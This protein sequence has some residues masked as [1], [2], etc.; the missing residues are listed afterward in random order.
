M[1]GISK[2]DRTLA[3]LLPIM[4]QLPIPENHEPPITATPSY[5]E[6]SEPSHEWVLSNEDKEQFLNTAY[7]VLSNTV[8]K[9]EKLKPL[10][11]LIKIAKK[12]NL[13]YF[14][15]EEIDVYE[16]SKAFSEIVVKNKLQLEATNGNPY[17]FLA[18]KGSELVEI[19]RPAVQACILEKIKEN[20]R[21]LPQGRFVFYRDKDIPRVVLN[22]IYLVGYG[23]SEVVSWPERF[24]SA[25]S[26]GVVNLGERTGEFTRDWLVVLFK[27]HLPRLVFPTVS[28]SSSSQGE[29]PAQP[30]KTE[31]EKTQI[32][33]GEQA[34]ESPTAQSESKQPSRTFTIPPLVI[35]N[36]LDAVTRVVGGSIHV[37]GGSGTPTSYNA[38][39]STPLSGPKNLPAGPSATQDHFKRSAVFDTSTGGPYV[40][41]NGATRI[42]VDNSHIMEPIQAACNKFNA[43]LANYNS[44]QE[45]LNN[46]LKSFSSNDSEADIISKNSN[47]KTI[48]QS[49]STELR[50]TLDAGWEVHKLVDHKA[51]KGYG[52]SEKDNKGYYH[53]IN[54]SVKKVLHDDLK[55]PRLKH[56][57]KK[58]LDSAGE[59]TK[60]KTL[61]NQAQSN[62]TSIKTQQAFREH[63]AFILEIESADGPTDLK[64][65]TGYLTQMRLVGSQ[66][67]SQL[68]QNGALSTQEVADSTKGIEDRIAELTSRYPRYA[69][70]LSDYDKFCDF[71]KSQLP[72]LIASENEQEIAQGLRAA[73]TRQEVLEKSIEEL[74]ENCPANLEKNNELLAI[75]EDVASRV[76]LM[77]FCARP[78]EQQSSELGV[79]K[80]QIASATTDDEREKAIEGFQTR[81]V[82]LS[83]QLAARKDY[84]KFAENFNNF[85][86]FLAQ[87]DSLP[88]MSVDQ[89]EVMSQN[90]IK[91]VVNDLIDPT[92]SIA[93]LEAIEKKHVANAALLNPLRITIGT[94]FYLSPEKTQAQ[95]I[96]WY[97]RCRKIQPSEPMWPRALAI[98]HLQT[99]H[100][101]EA[102][103]NVLDALNMAPE[104]P[105]NQAVAAQIVQDKYQNAS[106][107]LEWV[108]FILNSLTPSEKRAV[109]KL[110]SLAQIL[111][112][113]SSVASHPSLLKQW[114]PQL[115]S[116]S[117]Q[118]KEELIKLLSQE[119]DTNFNGLNV[120]TLA[121][122]TISAGA[123]L[124]ESHYTVEE[125]PI[126]VKSARLLGGISNAIQLWLIPMV[127]CSHLRN[128]GSKYATN[129]LS[130]LGYTHGAA[131]SILLPLNSLIPFVQ[132]SIYKDKNE[133]I[134]SQKKYP[135]LHAMVETLGAKHFGA[136]FGF[137]ELLWHS[138]SLIGRLVT[139]LSSKTSSQTVEK[140]VG[141]GA[142]TF[143]AYKTASIYLRSK[144]EIV[145]SQPPEPKKEEPPQPKMG[146][147]ETVKSWWCALGAKLGFSW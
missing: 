122:R 115:L 3:F 30:S 124:I 144:E 32:Q 50:K 119:I 89:L 24:F 53:D 98:S 19:F 5:P 58:S 146:I 37:S 136:V 35:P 142:V 134:E 87:E 67:V 114:L 131:V 112:A 38:Q 34:Q 57:E 65:L 54:S 49:L 15:K 16:L 4:P 17:G 27:E 128:L 109:G 96:L 129:H 94:L 111:K 104:D 117:P 68:K 31:E 81:S 42:V 77:T 102:E 55:V 139:R 90:L 107:A 45:E 85:A 91:G 108:Q 10:E 123:G 8:K 41:E 92:Q 12:A 14:H 1:S 43:Q 75:Q 120:T 66:L 145:G 99:L 60:W 126:L 40:N 113:A 80:H 82:Y 9:S 25:L 26:S 72:Q 11:K 18:L 137:Y 125:R 84:G 138:R 140:V 121:N 73:E 2:P 95:A 132:D 39:I 69:K 70:I 118:L 51:V 105:S 100:Y 97:E 88:D 29:L 48:A 135:Y 33:S 101:T 86:A 46:E 13:K 20:Q 28:H 76:G 79:L 103:K 63:E 21:H 52:K 7:F 141:I 116:L 83:L 23:I 130:M 64:K 61:E 143:F 93:A 106:L 47:V 147:I 71:E 6:N 62:I 127:A 56:F 36:K 59:F 78:Y 110:R 133:K 44:K 74:I 22:N